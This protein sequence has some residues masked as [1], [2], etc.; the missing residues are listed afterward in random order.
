MRRKQWTLQSILRELKGVSVRNSVGT[1]VN[2][3]ATTVR[4]LALIIRLA[5]SKLLAYASKALDRAWAGTTFVFA[6]A[7]AK[8]IELVQLSGGATFCVAVSM[9]LGW[10]GIAIASA[11]VVL[12]TIPYELLKLPPREAEK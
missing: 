12:S 1:A 2:W 4:K 9:W 5:V 8:T 10:L 3:V 11:C 6:R 7:K